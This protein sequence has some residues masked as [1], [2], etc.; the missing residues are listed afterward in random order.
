M[1]LLL[2][3]ITIC[4]TIQ[5]TAAQSSPSGHLTETE[6]FSFYSHYWLNMHHFLHHFSR[7][8]EAEGNELF[9]RRDW[10]DLK[11]FDSAQLDRVLV[12]Y[13]TDLADQDLRTSDYMSK[14]KQWIT[15][16]DQG[17]IHI[18]EVPVE[19][20][21]H[22]QQLLVISDIYR[23]YFWPMHAEKIHE[24]LR[25]NLDLILKTEQ[26]AKIRL[27]QLTRAPWQT[28]K[29]RV[30]ICIVGKSYIN[31]NRDRPYT[32]LYPTHIVMHTG[33][34]PQ[35]NWLE[36]LYHEAS[37]HLITPNSG[38][39]SKTIKE[40][41]SEQSQ[42]APRQL[43][44]AYLFYFSGVTTRQL[45]MEQGFEDYELYMIR[46]RV[47]ERTFPYLQKHLAGYLNGELSLAAVTKALISDY[48][49]N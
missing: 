31:S 43:W 44:H 19:F 2:S 20:K 23:V 26:K 46:N 5:T 38:F 12:Y 24:T 15:T 25:T 42:A 14:F 35:G 29:I 21:G 16:Q 36:I 40:A 30:D 34:E 3:M 47:F 32:S 48:H 27:S 49:R 8:D 10:P 41:A 7:S 6:V 9:A 45:L 28:E 22:V 33:N 4:Y 37:H 17:H 18:E 13:K 1:R 11:A 39:V